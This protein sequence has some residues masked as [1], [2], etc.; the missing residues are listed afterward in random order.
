MLFHESPRFPEGISYGSRGGPG[1]NTAITRLDSGSEH[2]VARW[3][4]GLWSGNAAYGVKTWDDMS[5][6]ISFYRARMG[7]AYGFRYKDFSDFTSGNNHRD[8]PTATDCQI[9]T[10]DSALVA[11]QLQKKYVSG[12]TTVFRVV[13]KPVTG[14]VLIAVNGT[15]TVSGWAVDTTT[16]VV[17]FGV[18]PGTGD[19]ITAGF[20]FDVPGRFGEEADRVLSVSIDNFDSTSVPDIPIIEVKDTT[21]ADP[22]GVWY[23]GAC[24]HTLY[25]DEVLSLGTGRVQ[26]IDAMAAGLKVRLPDP[27]NFPTGATHFYIV[28]Q[29]ANSFEVSSIDGA[30]TYVT[31]AS[32]ECTEAFLSV[33]G[34][35]VK[36]WYVV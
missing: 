6:L 28:N 19:V 1:F 36:V 29:G 15:P 23:G 9:G 16:G 2:R 30:T 33:D 18:A 21:P 3:E 10:G 31:L 17:T 32:G 4:E 34:T 25:Q 27:V 8:A 24:E 5:D 11:F 22:Q 7:S 26:V 20:E 12:A 13:S 35:G 14:T